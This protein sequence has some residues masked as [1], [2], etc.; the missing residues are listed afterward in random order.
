MPVSTTHILV[1]GVMGVGMARGIAALDLRVIGKILLSWVVTLPM[2]SCCASCS[3][4][5]WKPSKPR[6]RQNLITV[7]SLT[8]ERDARSTMR[9]L[10]TSLALSNTK[11]ATLASDFLSSDLLS[12]IRRIKLGE[13]KEHLLQ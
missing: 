1:G 11:S 4:K 3:L 6:A 2:P 9:M 13:F 10:I 12:V 7:G 8:C 5:D